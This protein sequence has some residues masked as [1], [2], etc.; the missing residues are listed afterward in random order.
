MKRTKEELKQ[1]FENGDKPNQEQFWDWQDSYWHKDELIPKEKINGLTEVYK[2]Y[3]NFV[4]LFNQFG[5]GTPTLTILENNLGYIYCGRV[6]EG[7]YF[8]N[9]LSQFNNGSFIISNQT[10]RDNLGNEYKF[11][12][13]RINYTT[14]ILKVFF[15]GILSEYDNLSRIN[16]NFDRNLALEIRVYNYYSSG[17]TSSGSGSMSIGSGTISSG[18]YNSSGS[19]SV[20]IGG[21][22]LGDNGSGSSGSGF[23]GSGSSGSGNLSI[24]SSNF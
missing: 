11:I 14:I 9:S 13:T 2:P 21:G 6:S 3:K 4:A 8:I 22:T 7:V 18:S 12:F 16:E 15:N 10:I 23:T 5:S 20:S 1:F 17:T 24:G 19:G